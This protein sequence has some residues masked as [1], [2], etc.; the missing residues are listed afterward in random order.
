MKDFNHHCDLLLLLFIQQGEGSIR[1]DVIYEALKTWEKRYIDLA[2]DRMVKD[3]FLDDLSSLLPELDR[4]LAGHV[5]YMSGKGYAFIQDGGYVRLSKQ[6]FQERRKLNLDSFK[7][8]WEMIIS[9]ISLAIS[10]WALIVS[11]S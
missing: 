9:F 3:G 11:S 2:L 1:K 4:A 5:Y 6:I 7:V 10:I 8:G